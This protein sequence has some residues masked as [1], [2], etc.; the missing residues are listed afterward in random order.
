MKYRSLSIRHELAEQKIK[1]YRS[2]GNTE[3]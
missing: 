3:Y 1:Q 2:L